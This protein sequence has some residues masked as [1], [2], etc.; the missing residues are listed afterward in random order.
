LSRLRVLSIGLLCLALMGSVILLGA[1]PW[2]ITGPLNQILKPI[3]GGTGWN[4]SVT[5]ALWTP[6]RQLE[7]NDLHVQS[8]LGGRLHIVQLKIFPHFGSLIHGHLAT[9]WDVGEI[10]MDPGSWGIRKPLAQEMLSAGP[11][12]L[13]G[14]AVVQAQPGKMTLQLLELHGPMLKLHASGWV[15]RDRRA[16]LS[17]QGSLSRGLLESMSLMKSDSPELIS[18]EPFEMKLEGA[19]ARPRLSFASNFISVSFNPSGDKKI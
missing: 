9:R 17:L 15:T 18:W 11:V 6:W 5:R 13:N 4:F 16:D 1:L 12:T 19:L 2:R 8:P 14:V 10:R 3:A 7:I